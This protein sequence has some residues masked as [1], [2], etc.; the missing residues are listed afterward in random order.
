WQ[1]FA[2]VALGTFV[3]YVTGSRTAFGFA[4]L[5]ALLHAW[6]AWRR[7][8]GVSFATGRGLWVA[9]AT[10][11]AAL[12]VI[13]AVSGGAG[14]LFASRYGGDDLTSGRTATWAQTFREFRSAG[15]VEKL[16]GDTRTSRAVVV[17]DGN[18]LTTDNAV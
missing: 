17:R 12:G 7:S 5:A 10:S 14:F 8:R 4:V 1:R 2:A 16:F 18:K 15:V 13:V 6:L 11:F 9:V 3:V